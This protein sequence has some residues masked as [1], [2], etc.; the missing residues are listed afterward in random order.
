MSLYKEG[1]HMMLPSEDESI[2]RQAAQYFHYMYA[3]QETLTFG[4]AIEALVILNK[5]LTE[6]LRA[7]E[8]AE[9]DRA[10]LSVS[11]VYITD[12]PLAKR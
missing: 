3:D 4:Q 10:M 5:A 1:I 2:R 7:Y 9:L 8:K 11:P 12:D 6:R